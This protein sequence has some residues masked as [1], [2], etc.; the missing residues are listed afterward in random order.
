MI[1]EVTPSDADWINSPDVSA[2]PGPAVFG[3][4]STVTT[5][6]VDIKIRARRVAAIGQIR[7]LLQDGSGTTVGT[8]PWQVLTDT[9]TTYTMSITTTGTTARARLEVQ[10]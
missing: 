9:F 3:L 6:P 4:S 7:V 10:S 5:G 2:T 1:D 8:S